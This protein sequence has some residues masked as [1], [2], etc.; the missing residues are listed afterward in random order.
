MAYPR[1]S[2]EQPWLIPRALT[3]SCCRGRHGITCLRRPIRI[4]STAS[5][6]RWRRLD[7]SAGPHPPPFAPSRLGGPPQPQ[8]APPPPPEGQPNTV[9]GGSP[10]GGAGRGPG[11]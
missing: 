7:V 6:V 5:D 11:V 2:T 10:L 3:G 4:G 9:L 1:H 8:P